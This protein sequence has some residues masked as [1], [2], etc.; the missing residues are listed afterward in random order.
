MS[1]W[2]QARSPAAKLGLGLF[3]ADSG[4]RFDVVF[5]DCQCGRLHTAPFTFPKALHDLL[6]AR[7]FVL[8]AFSPIGYKS[9]DRKSRISGNPFVRLHL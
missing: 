9:L 3:S 5:K 8:L 1:T 6:T 7:W 4:R 2:A